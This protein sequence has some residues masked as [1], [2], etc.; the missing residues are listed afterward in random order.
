MIV[1]VRT[2][3]S[4]PFLDTHLMLVRD[5]D[6]LSSV[7]AR[8]GLGRSTGWDPGGAPAAPPGRG[9]L[10]TQRNPAR[11]SQE[12]PPPARGDRPVRRAVLYACR[13]Q[14]RGGPDDH[15]GARA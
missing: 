11:A 15:G 4:T 8:G 6:Q 7:G 10:V 12:S 2:S 1:A 3:S 13:C 9:G 5:V 14:S